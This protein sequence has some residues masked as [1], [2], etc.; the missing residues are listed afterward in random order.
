[1]STVKQ[2]SLSD[3]AILI[4]ALLELRTNR[5]EAELHNL[6][7]IQLS[8]GEYQ[9]YYIGNNTMAFAVAGVRT[10]NFLH[11]GKTLYIDDLVTHSSYRNQGFG[12]QLLDFIKQFVKE[13]NYEHLSLDSGFQRKE[14]YRLYLNSG[15]EVASLH[16]GRNVKEL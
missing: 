3:I 2:A 9:V 7:K 11:S 8:S 13:N 15:F 4:P 1:M 10:L 5:T 14:A 12:S 16:F 6:L